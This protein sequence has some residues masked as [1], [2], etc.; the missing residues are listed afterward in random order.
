M[1]NVNELWRL[2]LMFPELSELQFQILMH[3]SFGSDNESIAHVLGCSVVAVKKSLMR[4]KN[5]LR[6]D[7]LDTAR[8]I[9]HSRTQTALMAPPDFPKQYY[10][11]MSKKP[12]IDQP[13]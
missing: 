9:Y 13:H 10:E 4:I 6:L 3:Y 11:M 8:I 1:L 7:K 2:R 12:H 5:D